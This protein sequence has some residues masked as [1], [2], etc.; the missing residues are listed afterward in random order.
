MTN[1]ERV[2]AFN[3]ATFDKGAFFAKIGY[4]PDEWQQIF[5]SSTARHRLLAC[6]VRVGKTFTLAAEAAAATLCPSKK[7]AE[8]GEWVGSRVWIVA[9]TY[10]SAD[11]LFKLAASYLRRYAPKGFVSGYSE[12]EPI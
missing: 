11:K 1:T 12:R 6:G 7:S 2:P 9:P 8:A 3:A 4:K 10:D 5:H